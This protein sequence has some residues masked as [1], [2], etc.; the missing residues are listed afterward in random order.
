MAEPGIVWVMLPFLFMAM[1][2]GI[3]DLDQ[4]VRPIFGEGVQVQVFPAKGKCRQ[5]LVH[6]L[7]WHYVPKDLYGVDYGLVGD[8]LDAKY[9]AFLDDVEKVRDEQVKLLRRL[10]KDHGLKTIFSEGLS[11]GDMPEYHK[12]MKALKGGEKNPALRA[13]WLEVGSPGSLFWEAEIL[14][15]DDAAA[16]EAGNPLGQNK[17]LERQRAMVRN[18]LGDRD[19]AL[20]VLGAGHDLVGVLPGDCE[21]VRVKVNGIK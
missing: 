13:Y 6:I 8:E 12:M 5:R 21:Y 9:A 16:L 1:L 20:V 14:P 4:D 18:A 3:A 10:V 17:V 15:L 11:K 2:G 7:D 19:F